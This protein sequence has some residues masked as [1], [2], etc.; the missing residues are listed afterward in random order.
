MTADNLPK[1]KVPKLERWD[2]YI[3][4]NSPVRRWEFF[5]ALLVENITQGVIFMPKIK[6]LFKEHERVWF[7]IDNDET[8]VRFMKEVKELGGTFLNGEPIDEHS[9]GKVMA[10]GR[11]NKLAYVSLMVWCMA[12]S[13]E[14]DTLKVDY[15]K[16]EKGDKDYVLKKCNF[17][18]T[19]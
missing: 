16:Y 6:D 17:R 4:N 9:C 2:K 10:F 8:G 5:I 14:H 13:T 19:G 12:F 18:R 15:A 7:Y 11:N 1:G 3:V